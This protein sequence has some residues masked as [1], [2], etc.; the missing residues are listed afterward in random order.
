MT[1][2]CSATQVFA[3][4]C[5]ENSTT[6]TQ[7]WRYAYD[8]AGRMSRQTPP[9][10]TTAS[11]LATSIWVY[12][13]GGRMTARC[14]APAATA[15][16]ASAGVYRTVTPN[17][18]A[19]GR[20]IQL[21]THSGPGT[22]LVLRTATTFLGDGQ[23][24]RTT[25]S[26]GTTPTVA[27]TI[28]YAYDSAGRQTKVLRGTTVLS[29]Q[30]FRPDGTVAW[31]KDGDN[32]AIGQTSFTY[33]WAQ[34]LLSVDLP[35]AFSTAVPTFS[36][37]LDGLLGGRTWSAGSATFSYD[38]AKRPTGLT[39]GA[40]T[41]T[42]AYDRDGNVAAEVRNFSG[43]SGDAGT[44]TQTF[45]YDALDRVTGS[46][47]LVSGARTYKYD[48]N[49]NR[50]QKVTGG[51]TFDYSF[52]R[53]DEL[54]SV[55]K[56]GGTTQSFAYDPFGNMTG[57]AQT[58]A[59]VT[60][61]SY[62]LGDRLTGIDAAGTANDA[63]FTFDALGRFRTRTLASADGTDT[64]SYLD[65][66]ETV[67]RIDNTVAGPTD[68]MV[69]SR[70]DRIGVKVGATVNWFLSDLHG[71]IAASLDTT[72]AIVVN[73]IRYDAYGETITTGTAG[74]VR[75][76]DRAWKYQGRLDISPTGL[77]T[78]LYDMSARFYNPG[79]AAFTQ[80]DTVVGEARNPISMNRF[81]YGHA[82]PA[83]LS[84]PTGHCAVNG[85]GG[86]FD[87]L[88]SI[89]NCLGA[90]AGFVVGTAESGI[91]IVAETAGAVWSV[92]GHAA[93][94]GRCMADEG[95]RTPTI[96]GLRNSAAHV[97]GEIHRRGQ[98]VLAD[99]GAAVRRT[100]STLAF[101]GANWVGE[102]H[103]KLTTQGGFEGGRAAGHIFGTTVVGGTL[104]AAA[105][106]AVARVP[107]AVRG[108][109]GVASRIPGAA[110]AGW[111]LNK[112]RPHFRAKTPTIVRDKA[113]PNPGSGVTPC[114]TCGRPI[115]AKFPRSKFGWAIDHIIPWRI[116]NRLA[117]AWM[118]KLFPRWRPWLYN[119]GPNLRVRCAP[120]N[121]RDN[122]RR[123]R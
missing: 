6:N 24:A 16:C 51:I 30:G 10:N 17:Y 27:D 31:R 22:T 78:P 113:K 89:G 60:A 50:T 59:A 88:G 84:D 109:A 55:L 70:G 47:G 37:R 100:V 56:T 63:T 80:L 38:A 32:N 18:D 5:D 93:D 69:S 33:D 121:W 97:A 49:S 42:Q 66:S 72:E 118:Q 79:I 108:A 40:L 117:P 111:T 61:N 95:C 20:A 57:D 120:C 23:P 102:Q 122:G 34:R 8:D 25:Y 101:A 14:E 29:E 19:V 52:D 85:A 116:L 11:A 90:G 99:P 7:A 87:P 35:D 75:V 115:T 76:G 77:A 46:S 112:A 9:V 67:V 119:F 21:D 92:P 36:W 65:A 13:A 103:R 68:S 81:L 123:R 26:T 74:G 110:R 64:Y 41:E 91:G 48:R 53:T 82:N 39:K 94:I 86:G 105:P 83:T 45:T 28:D 43:I 71:S 58:G 3:G 114:P 106:A 12:D 4:G 98:V 62:D 96:S 44:G 107:A 54:V 1:G 104:L 2:Y 73:A 15:N